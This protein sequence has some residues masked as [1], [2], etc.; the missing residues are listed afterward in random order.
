LA[1][2]DSKVNVPLT[3]SKP[4]A[5]VTTQLIFANPLASLFTGYDTVCKNEPLISVSSSASYC[6]VG[7]K[8]DGFPVSCSLNYD[9]GFSGAVTITVKQTGGN[10]DYTASFLVS[11]PK[12]PNP[13]PPTPSTKSHTTAIVLGVIGGIVGLGIAIGVAWYVIKG[14]QDANVDPY[15]EDATGAPLTGQQDA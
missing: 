3:R 4:G 10:P 11:L 1:E 5:T 7:A 14:R 15:D 9:A 2:S 12:N 13:A 6:T 8:A